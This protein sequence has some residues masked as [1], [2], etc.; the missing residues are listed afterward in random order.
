M[1]TTFSSSFSSSS[2][3]SRPLRAQCLGFLSLCFSFSPQTSCLPVASELLPGQNNCTTG[4]VQPPL[5]ELPLSLT[6]WLVCNSAN[7]PVY[8]PASQL[9]QS[10]GRQM[11][12]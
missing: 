6:G 2:S 8:K 9:G 4:Q 11:E 10:A 12:E 3:G 5:A 1:G 7:L